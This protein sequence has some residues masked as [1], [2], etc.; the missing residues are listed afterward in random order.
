MATAGHRSW[1]WWNH[2]I[3]PIMCALLGVVIVCGAMD[4]KARRRTTAS[5]S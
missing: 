4:G 3:L 5:S 1:T 2:T